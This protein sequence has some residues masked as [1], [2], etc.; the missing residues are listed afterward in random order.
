MTHILLKPLKTKHTNGSPLG[1]NERIVDCDLNAH[2]ERQRTNKDSVVQL[3][4]TP[5]CCACIFA[6][7]LLYTR[8]HVNEI[9]DCTPSEIV[10]QGG[11]QT[12]NISPHL[13]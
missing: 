1:L 9:S 2:E 6:E 7:N 11:G 4:S 10:D 8:L 5:S 12:W 13:W 3:F